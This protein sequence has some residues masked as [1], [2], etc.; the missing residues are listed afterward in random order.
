MDRLSGEHVT[1]RCVG[2]C[3][4]VSV[5]VCMCFCVISEG[6]K[7]LCEGGGGAWGVALPL[8]NGARWAGRGEAG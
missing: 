6:K 7:I 8:A 1:M 4:C 2:L 3:V 5:P